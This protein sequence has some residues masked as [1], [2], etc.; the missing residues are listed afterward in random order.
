MG[1]DPTLGPEMTGADR[2]R[3]Y[4]ARKHQEGWRE[5]WERREAK[6]RERREKLRENLSDP[7][8]MR[9]KRE[10]TLQQRKAARDVARK[11]KEQLTGEM[12]SPL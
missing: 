2:I 3:R 5:V 10:A 7:E 11:R 1:S 9:Q 8:A 12:S 4:R 6:E